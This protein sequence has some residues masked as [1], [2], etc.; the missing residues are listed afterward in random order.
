MSA[1]KRV[2]KESS[3]LLFSMNARYQIADGAGGVDLLNDA[4][5]WLESANGT[6]DLLVTGLQD[7][8]GDVA[9]DPRMIRSSLAGVQQHLQMIDGAVNAV[10][11]H[12]AKPGVRD[13]GRA[14]AEQ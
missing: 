8:D 14:L 2:E 11:S 7:E 10:F 3:P 9:S 12:L 13:A 5:T 1:K 6:I 4:L